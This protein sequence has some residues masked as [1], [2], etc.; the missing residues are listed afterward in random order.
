MLWSGKNVLE[1]GFG[2][3]DTLAGELITLDTEYS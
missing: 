3:M 1:I 2:E